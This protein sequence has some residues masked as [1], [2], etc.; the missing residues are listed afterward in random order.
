MDASRGAFHLNGNL[1][2]VTYKGFRTRDG[3]EVCA[4]RAGRSLRLLDRP[5]R[6]DEW[7]LSI[8][9]DYLGDPA[10]ALDLYQE[11]ASLTINRFTNDWELSGSDI[12]N[13]LMELEILRGRWRVALMR[14]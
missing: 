5:G 6:Q 4:A 10:R 13:V 11:F 3:W 9:T 1:S 7:S 14:G 2:R 8:L 12:D